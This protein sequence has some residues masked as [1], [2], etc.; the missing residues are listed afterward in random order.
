MRQSIKGYSLDHLQSLSQTSPWLWRYFTIQGIFFFTQ[1]I[2]SVQ[3]NA[4]LAITGCIRGTFREKLY[5]EFGLES[6][7]DRRFCWRLFVFY[8][9]INGTSPSYLLQGLPDHNLS[10]YALRSK[11]AVYQSAIRTKR[12][13]NSFFHYCIS[14][15]N[16]LDC[17]IRNLPT[18]SS[19]KRALS[20]FFRPSP[21]SIFKVNQ[22]QGIVLL[23]RLRVGFSH[24]HEHKF[25]HNF[26][27]TLDPFCSCR[28]SSIETTE[29]YLL[30][31]SNHLN[32]LID[33]L[34]NMNLMLLPFKVYS[35]A[36]ILLFG[37]LAFHDDVNQGILRAIII[38]I[39]STRR[40]DGSLFDER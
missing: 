34:H 12:F 31:C 10:S 15:W 36:K 14:Q 21:A 5:P 23:A 9:V 37:D 18:I 25:R 33:S 19:F 16:A 38:F 22:P 11:P 24:L 1:K 26:M 6:L 4:A 20:K 29:H 17:Q 3:Y 28:T 39:L 27:D 30:Q 40:F 35:L 2:E 32:V 8:N 13:Q 7:A